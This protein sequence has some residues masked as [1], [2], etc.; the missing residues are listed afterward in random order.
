MEHE[1]DKQWIKSPQPRQI[2]ISLFKGKST[3]RSF[4]SKNSA[5]MKGHN[6]E[7]S[8]FE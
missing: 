8:F 2:W 6:F 3:K 5:K 4:E 7:E 1:F